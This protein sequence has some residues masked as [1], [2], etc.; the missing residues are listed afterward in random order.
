MPMPHPGLP[1]QWAPVGDSVCTP[2]S[3]GFWDE[4]V[5]GGEGLGQALAQGYHPPSWVSPWCPVMPDQEEVT[6]LGD[7]V[8]TTSGCGLTAGNRA[9]LHF[10]LALS[11][12]LARANLR[13]QG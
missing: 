12:H 13:P 3:P 7:R 8:G 1:R 4:G 10:I 5:C 9:F 2:G 11:N 6:K